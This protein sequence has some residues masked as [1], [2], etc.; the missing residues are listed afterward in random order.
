M[1]VILTIIKMTDTKLKQAN[2]IEAYNNLSP[3]KSFSK[4]NFPLTVKNQHIY[5][6]SLH[7]SQL[8]FDLIT[9]SNFIIKKHKP[10]GNPWRNNTLISSNKS[11]KILKNRVKMSSLSPQKSF[12]EHS[13]PNKKSRAPNTNLSLPAILHRKNSLSAWG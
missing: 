6:R 11:T 13:K 12:F 5:N 1:I 10:I 3:C 8:Q 2:F 4:L 7:P 9:N